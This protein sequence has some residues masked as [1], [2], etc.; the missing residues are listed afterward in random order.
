MQA[1][2][3]HKHAKACMNLLKEQWPMNDGKPTNIFSWLYLLEILRASKYVFVKTENNNV[4]GF[5]GYSKGTSYRFWWN[6]VFHFLIYWVWLFYNRKIF[7]IYEI[8]NTYR[9][10]IKLCDG[11]L[12]VIVID[13]KHRGKQYGA[14]LFQCVCNHA[15]K[16]NY[17][18]LLICTYEK[19]CD[20][21]FYD[22]MSCELF[23]KFRDPDPTE[24]IQCLLY[25]KQLTN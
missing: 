19:Y 15:V 10:F 6:I 7:Y 18:K 16:Q 12:T 5:T 13:K 25:I 9:P 4:I 14:E 24:N 8:Y 1:F 17:K 21:T 2:R 3:F 11:E 20:V 22:T 23:T